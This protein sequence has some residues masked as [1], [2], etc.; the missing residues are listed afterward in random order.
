MNPEEIRILFDE[1][2][3]VHTLKYFF[4]KIAGI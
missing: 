2:K 4:E 1:K 3:P